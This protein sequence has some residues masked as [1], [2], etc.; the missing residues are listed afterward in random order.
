MFTLD[1]PPGHT[2][3]VRG[4]A[5]VECGSLC[6]VFGGLFQRF[7]V[8]PHKQYPVE[9]PAVL[10]IES[11]VVVFVKGTTIPQDWNIE[12]SGVIALIGPTDVGKSSLSTY[13]LNV[14]VAKGRRVCVID[15]DVGQ[16]DIG[17][18][19]FVAYSCTS[20]PTPHISTLEPQ[21]GYY[22]GSTNLQGVEE[23]LIAGVIWSLRRATA[24]YPHLVIINTPGWTTGRGL[25][26]LKALIDAT[27]ATPVNIG[28]TIIPGPTASKPPY[29]LPRG[30]QERKELRNYAYR[31]YLKA[32]T[33][34]QVESERLALCRWDGGLECPWGRYVPADVDKPEKR[35]REYVVPP[36]YLRHIFAALYKDKRLVGYGVVE[37]FEPKIAMYA[38]TTEFDEVRIGK[39]RIDPDTRQELEPLP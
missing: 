39:I 1:I 32:T 19:G 10:K 26:L 28:D 29:V 12:T 18:P 16:S 9:G 35:G 23:L 24:Q 30:P 36:Q 15:A 31:R 38:T 6:R 8:P 7:E 37:K 20:A 13:L 14:H 17:P 27:G 4:P 34:A 25:Q 5:S 22:I 11:G 21:D 3:L 2:A 33:K